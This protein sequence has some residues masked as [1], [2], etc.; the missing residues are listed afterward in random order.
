MI[1]DEAYWQVKRIGSLQ[2]L[3]VELAEKNYKESRRA[4]SEDNPRMGNWFEGRAAT[5]AGVAKWIADCL[6]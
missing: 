3:L 6:K 4:F 5:Y 1:K 2:K